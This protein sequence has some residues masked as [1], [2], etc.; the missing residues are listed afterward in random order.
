MQFRDIQ[1]LQQQEE[2]E[3]VSRGRGNAVFFPT[4]LIFSINFFNA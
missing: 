1:W 4:T 2:G 3:A